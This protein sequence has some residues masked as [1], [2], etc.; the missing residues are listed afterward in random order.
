ME[1]DSIQSTELY[2]RLLEWFHANR[3]PLIIGGGAVAVIAIVIGVMSWQKGETEASADSQLLNTPL[4]S[5]KEGRVVPTP[6]STFLDLS[7]DYPSTSAGEYASLLGAESLF[8]SGKYPEAHEQFSKFIDDNPTSLLLAQAEVGLAASLEGEGKNQEAAQKYQQV[9]SG[10]P[11]E[12]YITSPVKLTLARLDEELN[13]PE[14]ALQYYQ[15]LMRINNPVDPWA[16]EARERAVSLIMKHPELRKALAP[17]A[18]AN[19][20]ASSPLLNVSPTAQKPGASAP[21]PAPRPAA[22]ATPAGGKQ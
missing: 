11:T 21:A 8:L 15:D 17:P 10:Y 9:L 1:S 19:P 12:E 2:I 3:K 4:A 20:G 7:K 13:R 16:A 5:L 18:G 22:P 14:Q 6:A